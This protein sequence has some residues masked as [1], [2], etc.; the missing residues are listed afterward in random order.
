MTA[1]EDDDLVDMIRSRGHWQVVLRPSAF[2]RDRVR[3]EDLEDTVRKAAVQLRG[4]DFPHLDA[5]SPIVRGKDWIEQSSEWNR[6]L[7]SWRFH[8]SGLFAMVRGMW[9]DWTD[10]E[11]FEDVPAGAKVVTVGELL[12][13]MTEAFEF[14]ARM[15]LTPAGDDRMHIDIAAKDL[16]GRHLIVGDRRR[17]EFLEPR[18]A[19]IDD[20]PQTF[21]LSRDELIA[22]PR[23]FALDASIQLFMRFGWLDTPRE[24]LVDM[25][26]ELR[27]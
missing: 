26:G 8:S 19:G 1:S 21:E 2:E 16:R 13:T 23:E 25:Q 18:V 4:W 3:Y 14:A 15:S 17:A 12:F 22:Q 24:S 11:G 20:F 7:E 6:H 9:T 27:S 10:R 5:R